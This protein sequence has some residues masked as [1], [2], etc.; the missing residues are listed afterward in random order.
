[1]AELSGDHDDDGQRRGGHNEAAAGSVAVSSRASSRLFDIGA[2]AVVLLLA[3]PVILVRSLLAMLREHRLFDAVERVGRQRRRFR[4]LRFA[5]ESWPASLAVWINVLRGDM[6][7][8]GPRALSPDEAHRVPDAAGARF[9]VPPGLISPYALRRQVGIAHE[10]EFSVDADYVGKRSLLR[11][12]GLVARWFLGR[13]IGGGDAQPR[14]TPDTLNFFG[15]PMA[16]ATM[17]DAVDWI[18]TSSRSGEPGRRLAFV[19]PDCLNIAWRDADYR[20]V[21]CEADR[22][23]ADGIGIRIGGQMLG[24]GLRDNVN[25][26][27]MFPLLCEAAAASGRSLFL[28]G[29]RPGIA[30]AV[31]AAMQTRFPSLEIAGTQDGYFAPADEDKVIAAINASGAAILLVAFGAP[32]Q[33][34]WIARH[35]AALSPPVAMG[36]GGLFDFYSGRIR[37][38]PVWMRELGME[39]VYRLM[40][41]PGRMWRRYIIGNPLFLYRVWIQKRHPGRFNL[42][43]NE[44]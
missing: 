16:N 2:S 11:D 8:V 21:L 39:W 19:N 18:I 43:G 1:M 24:W 5:G 41:E 13:L 28:L 44:R 12:I 33:E 14:A 40:Q 36:V 22:V 34:L 42:P 9:S 7:V 32:R 23:F 26:T 6:A 35:R 4:R 31:A 37:R 38:A 17:S 15:V 30:E 10:S 20:R 3:S 27:D 29:A 25:G